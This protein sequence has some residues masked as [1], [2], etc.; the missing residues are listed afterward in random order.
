MVQID[1]QGGKP[2]RQQ[3]VDTIGL[4]IPHFPGATKSTLPNGDEEKCGTYAA[5][6][7]QKHR[8]QLTPAQRRIAD[9][10]F[11]P[12]GT[13]VVGCILADGSVLHG[14]CPARPKT[15]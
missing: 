11:N 3:V 15:K 5:M 8:D 13:R 9:K 6:F 1:H 4:S 14:P 7:Y 12:S 10:H 2:T